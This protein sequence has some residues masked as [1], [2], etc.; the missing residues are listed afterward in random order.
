MAIPTSNIHGHFVFLRL[1]CILSHLGAIDV[2]NYASVCMEDSTT[3]T[4]ECPPDHA[5]GVE[6]AHFYRSHA[7]GCHQQQHDCTV[8]INTYYF[9]WDI[10]W[11]YNEENR[12]RKYSG[13]AISY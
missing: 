1:F 6:T 11:I 9:I 12:Y 5:L 13:L 7:P 10:V 4:L 2:E 8:R 3:L